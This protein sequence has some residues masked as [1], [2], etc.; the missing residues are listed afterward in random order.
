MG[1]EKLVTS[2]LYEKGANRRVFNI[3][4]HIGGVCDNPAAVI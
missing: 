4:L 3:D 2:K 1:V